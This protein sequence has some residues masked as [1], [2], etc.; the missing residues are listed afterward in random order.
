[1]VTCTSTAAAASA[2]MAARPGLLGS[3][4][5]SMGPWH[6]AACS[7][8]TAGLPFWAPPSPEA[9]AAAAASDRAS[10]KQKH[11]CRAHCLISQEG[12]YVS[13]G[14]CYQTD[15]SQEPKSAA[16]HL[17]QARRT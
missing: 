16:A 13:P 6:S 1:V 5:V 7:S 9:P 12:R 2:P 11:S 14:A 10:R 15:P 8:A 3:S 17:S 4:A